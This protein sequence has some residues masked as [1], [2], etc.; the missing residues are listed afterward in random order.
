[1]KLF[2]VLI[3]TLS[4]TGISS[5]SS[6]SFPGVHKISIQQGNVI[7]QKMVDKLKP[8][9]TKS[10]VRFVLGNAIIDDSLDSERWDYIYSIQLAGQKPFTQSMS[11]HFI[12]NK[13]SHFEGDYLPS[14][15]QKAST[16]G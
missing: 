15:E 11:L 6:F 5:C 13:L 4:I 16:D 7:T 1:M 14:S 3:L 12:D 9:M 2:S 10:Q 8:G